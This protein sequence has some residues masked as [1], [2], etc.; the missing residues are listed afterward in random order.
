MKKVILL[1]A[2]VFSAFASQAQTGDLLSFFPFMNSRV[3]QSDSVQVVFQLLTS[4][5]TAPSIAITQTAGPAV[6]FAPTFNWMEGSMETGTF[7]LQGLTPGTYT[8]TAAAKSGTGAT[9]SQSYTL[10]VVADPAA[11][12]V[13]SVT[14]L[15]YGIPVIIPAGQGTKIG[16]SNSTTQT[17]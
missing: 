3:H 4:S 9:S 7:W 16:F 17:Y 11:P 5:T 2:V 8:F 1:L 6:K 14:V 13:T 15:F 10:T 12:S